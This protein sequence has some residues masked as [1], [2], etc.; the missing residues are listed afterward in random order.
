MLKPAEYDRQES[1]DADP[2]PDNAAAHVRALLAQERRAAP[3]ES[4]AMKRTQPHCSREREGAARWMTLGRPERAR[5]AC[6]RS[7]VRRW[8]DCREPHLRGMA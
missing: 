4:L 3:A 1:E 6:T 7:S 2:G 5:G 8:R